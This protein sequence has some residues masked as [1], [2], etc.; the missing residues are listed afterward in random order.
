MKNNINDAKRGLIRNMNDLEPEDDIAYD[1]K[2]HEYDICKNG[3]HKPACYLATVSP[4]ED[5][6][7]GPILICSYGLIDGP[8]HCYSLLPK[9]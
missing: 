7:E 1:G 8:A 3:E 6:P 4:F 5:D 9:K 2:T